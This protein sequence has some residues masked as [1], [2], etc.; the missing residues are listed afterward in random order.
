[1]TW[2]RIDRNRPIVLLDNPVGDI[3]PKAGTRTNFFGREK[4]F[5]EMGQHIGRDTRPTVGDFDHQ[6]MILAARDQPDGATAR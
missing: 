3:Q 1:M 2:A 5:K 4:W 6:E